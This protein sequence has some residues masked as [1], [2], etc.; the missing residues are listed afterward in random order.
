MTPTALLPWA[1]LAAT[2]A[3]IVEEFVVPG[4]FL[5]WYRDYR[6]ERRASITPRFLFVLHA[7]LVLVSV[8]IGAL[9]ATR[10]GVAG[11]LT[12]TALLGW[13]GTAV[14]AFA[15]GS[16]YSLW[17]TLAHR[18]RARAAATAGSR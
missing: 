13:N 7:A 8:Q 9:G 4:G 5:A 2:L 17:A 6:P 11:W 18:R 16:S 14:A 12:V 10:L 3:H 15:I 1:P